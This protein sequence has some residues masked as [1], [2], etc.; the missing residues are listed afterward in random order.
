VTVP[1]WPRQT[2]QAGDALRGLLEQLGAAVTLD[3]AGLTVRGTGVLSGVDADL[4]EVGELTPVF[5][6]LCTLA[7]GPSRLRGLAHLRGHETDRLAALATGLSRLGADVSES[8]DGLLIRPRPLSAAVFDSH[9][10]HRMAQ[11]GAVL[12]LVVP[13]VQ[14]V[15][16]ATTGKTLPDF[17]GMWDAMLAREER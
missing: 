12:G 17:V 13:G 11:A 10:D 3:G 7:D 6:A 16:I 9:D 2:S 4:H 8:E 15:D 14:V 5:A 1:G